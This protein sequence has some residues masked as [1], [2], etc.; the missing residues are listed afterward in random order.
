IGTEEKC[1]YYRRQLYRRFTPSVK[2]Q[3]DK[4]GA[5]CPKR[6]IDCESGL[7]KQPLPIELKLEVD[8][9][10]I[11][12]A[13]GYEYQNVDLCSNQLNDDQITSLQSN[14]SE[15]PTISNLYPRLANPLSG[16]ISFTNEPDSIFS[17]EYTSGGSS[18]NI[19]HEHRNIDFPGLDEQ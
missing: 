1:E 14:D 7:P 15:Y 11:S 17:G 12:F 4:S 2:L 5:P 9:L 8:P 18:R 13:Y 19:Q 6:F 3:V 10:S 16:E